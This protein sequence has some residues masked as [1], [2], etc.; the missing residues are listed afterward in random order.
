MATTDFTK[1]LIKDDRIANL[2]DSV[3]YGVVKGGQ[4]ITSASYMAQSATNSAH[5]YSV[6]VPSEMVIISREVMW[7]NTIT[8][9][10]TGIP[11]DGDYLVNYGTTEAFAPFAMNQ[12]VETMSSTINNNTV[13]LNVK[14]VLAPILR[15]HDNRELSRYNGLTPTMVDTYKNYA[16]ADESANNPLGNYT[17]ITDN[18]V[19]PRGA[20]NIIRIVGNTVQAGGG[21]VGNNLKTVYITVQFTEP[22]LS[23]PWI[24]SNPESNNQGMYGVQ[25][26][27]FQFNLDSTCRRVWRTSR[28]IANYNVVVEGQGGATGWTESKLI[29]TYISPHPSDLLPSRNVVPYMNLERFIYNQ[30]NVLNFNTTTTLQ[31]QTLQLNSIPDRIFVLIRKR[32]T[33]QTYT[34]TDSFLTI[35]GISINFNNNSGLCSSMTQ[36]DLYKCSIRNG[37]NQSWQE[38]SG[39]ANGAMVDGALTSIPTSGSVLCL[40]FGTDIQL[41]EDYLSQGSIGSY[42]LSL[43]VDVLNQQIGAGANNVNNIVPELVII[44]QTSGIMVNEKGTCSTFLGLLTKSDVLEA[45]TQQPYSKSAVKRLV[46]GGWFD[47][48]KAVAGQVLPKVKSALPF[49]AP[50]LGIDKDNAKKAA[51]L[52]G[53]VG[54]GKGKLNSRLS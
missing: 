7:S 15:V 12:M 39:R 4:N 41:S 44:T 36:Q 23:S 49:V 2:T 42:Q 6:Q 8:I 47:D 25:T 11:A 54:Y 34:D 31:S 52:I 9:K 30:F 10:I 19:Q 3:K 13:S 24:F 32:M 38:F 33:D 45:S 53:A 46:G 17:N 5:T 18:D 40:A 27:H 28:A 29:F 26:L 48:L 1:V 14:D 21:F 20:F 16:D 22:L 51:E 43:K 50:M 37:I 35:Q